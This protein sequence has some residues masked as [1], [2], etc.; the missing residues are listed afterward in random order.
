MMR[1]P[2]GDVTSAIERLPGVTTADQSAALHIRGS[3][4]SD[5]AMVLDG[6]ELYDPFHLQ[7]FQDPVT[8]PAAGGGRYTLGWRFGFGQR[9]SASR[10]ACL[11]AVPQ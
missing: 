11:Q 3:S 2:G 10:S 1:S 4:T 9:L 7:S 8:H 5:V 6:L